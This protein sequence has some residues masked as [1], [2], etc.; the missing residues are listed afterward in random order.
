[1]DSIILF[2]CFSLIF[3]F[4]RTFA[5]LNTLNVDNIK[6]KKPK[7]IYQSSDRE[8]F[9]YYV[10]LLKLPPEEVWQNILDQTHSFQTY[11]EYLENYT[12]DYR[13][14]GILILSIIDFCDNK[15]KLAQ[16]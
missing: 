2:I 1:M 14:K 16:G 11:E 9:D 6:V 3:I 12:I 4:V 10:T 5:E 8:V 7:S 13:L 15:R